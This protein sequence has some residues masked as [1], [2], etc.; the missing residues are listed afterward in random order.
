MYNKFTRD[1]YVQAM[2]ATVL[3]VHCN[4]QAAIQ[5]CLQG[6]LVF[7]KLVQNN[8]KNCI[9][10]TI[11]FISLMCRTYSFLALMVL[12]R[13]PPDQ[14][15][16]QGQEV[17]TKFSDLVVKCLIKLTKALQSTLNVG[18]CSCRFCPLPGLCIWPT[19]AVIVT[20]TSSLVCRPAA[21]K[22]R[23]HSHMLFPDAVMHFCTQ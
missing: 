15:Q 16:Q 6:S 7:V 2:P 11:H 5:Q 20:P 8:Y 22:D 18:P 19:V 12:L 4:S 3:A 21:N 9:P 23:Q 1:Y 14:L 10:A 17:L 13:C